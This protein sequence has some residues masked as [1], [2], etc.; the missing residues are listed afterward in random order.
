MAARISSDDSV[1]I[2]NGAGYHVNEKFGFG[3]MDASRMVELALDWKNKPEQHICESDK[4]HTINKWAWILIPWI[5]I[6]L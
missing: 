2:V 4:I 1:W 3:M 5:L 6:A